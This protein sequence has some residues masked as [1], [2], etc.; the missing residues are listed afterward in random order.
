MNTSFWNVAWRGNI[1]FRNKYLR[2]FLLSNQKE[3]NVAELGEI[4]SRDCHWS[5]SSRRPLFVCV[6]DLLRELLV[7]LEGFRGTLEEDVWVWR[8]EES[9]VFTVKSM[10]KKLEV[11]ML[12]EISILEAQGKVFSNIWKSPAPSKVVAFSW[13][14]FHD[15]IPSKV[16]LA[17]RHVLPL[18]ASLNCALCEGMTESTNHLFIHCELASEVW[19][20]LLTWLNFNFVPP[21][22]LFLHWECWNGAVSNKKV[23]KRYQL[24][25][26]PAI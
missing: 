3:A 12:E 15:R 8:L 26:H 11:R 25:W 10:Y 1:A 17:H 7:E 22:N 5:F 4:N 19:Q 14:L 24:I 20:G 6:N 21:T 9:G 13:K 23:C 18:E 16:N 2:F